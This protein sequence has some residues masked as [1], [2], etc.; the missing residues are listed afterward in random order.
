MAK[1]TNL[2]TNAD[3]NSFVTIDQYFAIFFPLYLNALA[4]LS[5]YF[6]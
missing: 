4:T 1:R 6:S 5:N 3:G 2:D